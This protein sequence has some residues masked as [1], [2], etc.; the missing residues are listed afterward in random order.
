MVKSLFIT[1]FKD[2]KDQLI[3][4]MLWI[5]IQFR[6]DYL[7]KSDLKKCCYFSHKLRWG[8][9]FIPYDLPIELGKGSVIHAPSPNCQVQKV[10]PLALYFWCK[11]G[12]KKKFN[13]TQLKSY[14]PF[15]IFLL[16]LFTQ[17]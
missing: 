17:L 8:G 2:I 6:K 12:F 16:N 5:I 10:R 1:Q 14:L 11:G 15:L 9:G 3:F 4:L 13:V 7:T